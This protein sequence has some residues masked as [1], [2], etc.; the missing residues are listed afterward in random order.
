MRPGLL[1][2]LLVSAFAGRNGR[3]ERVPMPPDAQAMAR[4]FEEQV[5]MTP[6]ITT[7]AEPR[8]SDGDS[9][10]QADSGS[11]ASTSTTTAGPTPRSLTDVHS[12]NVT[13]Q[14][15]PDD[16]TTE[17]PAGTPAATAAPDPTAAA[18]DAPGTAKDTNE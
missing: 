16:G 8:A 12:T 15:T 18:T 11:K 13:N 7:T 3:S 9:Q 1:S 17:T 6:S 4:F 2:W 10:S 5:G 14:T